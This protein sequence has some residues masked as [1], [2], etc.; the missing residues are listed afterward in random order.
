MKLTGIKCPQCGASSVEMEANNMAKCLYCDT[1]F[2]IE[3]ENADKTELDKKVVMA[4]FYPTVN[5]DGFI[6][7][8]WKQIALN[9]PPISVYKESLSKPRVYEI[10]LAAQKVIFDVQYTV[11]I[12]RYIDNDKLNATTKTQ[13]GILDGIEV[14]AIEEALRPQE[15]EMNP[16]AFSHPLR[17]AERKWM[18]ADKF[19]SIISK[20]DLSNEKDLEEYEKQWTISKELS[21][22]DSGLLSFATS[23]SSWNP[24]L[25]GAQTIAS[26]QT[27][28]EVE[29]EFKETNIEEMITK[30]L[31]N[32]LATRVDVKLRSLFGGKNVNIKNISYTIIKAEV[33]TPIV[34]YKAYRYESSFT[35]DNQMYIVGLPVKTKFYL[36][37]S[38]D[39]RDRFRVY[40]AAHK[41]ER[42]G[43]IERKKVKPPKPQNLKEFIDRYKFL[44]GAVACLIVAIV[45]IIAQADYIAPLVFMGGVALGIV[46]LII[47]KKKY[48][49]KT[50]IYSPKLELLNKK[51]A[52]LNIETVSDEEYEEM[53][54]INPYF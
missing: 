43:T 46:H 53:K 2:T 20:Y 14:I 41:D 34:F 7:E 52:S 8:A 10:L 29:M 31:K 23:R 27:L 5:G 35:F 1:Q 36:Q 11:V 3:S 33:K 16:R 50:A 30:K 18:D 28:K 45:L 4:Q 9:D 17:T 21:Y 26:N 38:F 12:E 42:P 51:L 40:L 37:E 15:S 49:S 48:P 13:N 44:L 24:D 19:D 25:S 32:L 54:R 22:Y 6:R 47:S 39:L